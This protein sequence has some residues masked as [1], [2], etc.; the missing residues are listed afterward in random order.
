MNTCGWIR[1]YQAKTSA[2]TE[3]V[4]IV[5]G[6]LSRE[7]EIECHVEES[8]TDY[9]VTLGTREVVLCKA[10]CKAAQERGGYALDRLILLELVKNGLS[11]KKTRSQY[12][13]YCHS[14]FFRRMDGTVY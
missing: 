9:Q 6:T 12:I 5:S 11:Y 4:K 14:I 13:R 3:F 7:F 8:E 2:P 10:D 1:G